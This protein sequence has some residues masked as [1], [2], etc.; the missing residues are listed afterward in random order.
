MTTIGII[1]TGRMAMV[2]HALFSRD[3]QFV[4][5]FASRSKKTDGTLIFPF[6]DVLSCDI[7]FLAV[8]ISETKKLLREMSPLLKDKNPL[9]IDICSVKMSP[10]LWLRT[11]LPTHI[12][13]VASH[14]IFGPV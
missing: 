1:G 2:L 4:I 6:E 3:A 12:D 11:I 7:L 10:V 9:V 13:C 5:K 14:P 8:P